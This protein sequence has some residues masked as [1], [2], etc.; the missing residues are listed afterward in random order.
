MILLRYRSAKDDQDAIPSYS[1]DY[2]PIPL[3]YM[4][5]QLIQRMQLA[6]PCLQAA[7]RTLHGGSYQRATQ[8]S[9]HFP[10]IDR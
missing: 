7:L 9:D 10:F 6:L 2:A 3:G 4:V 1:T 5:G 8:D